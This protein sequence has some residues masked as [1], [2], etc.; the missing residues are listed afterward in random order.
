MSAAQK[1]STGSVDVIRR[2][3]EHRDWVNHQ[4]LAAA[5]TLSDD[6]LR[7]PLAIGQGSVWKSLLHLLAAEFVWLEALRGNEQ[8]VITGDLADKLPGN[9]QGAGGIRSLAELD[10]R[11]R[12]LEGHWQ[13]YLAELS[14]DSL[15]DLVYRV[16][17]NGQRRAT[18][19]LDTLLHVCTHAHYTAAQVMNML[20]QLGVRDLPDPMLISMARRQMSG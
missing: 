14:P 4:L 11:W 5:E 8:G 7:A 16:S 17:S 20:R 18:R 12:E 1:P 10:S 6:A 9:Q 13:A 15:D 2:L 19:R 3:H